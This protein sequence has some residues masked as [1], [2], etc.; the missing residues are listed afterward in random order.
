MQEIRVNK[1]ETYRSFVSKKRNH[2]GALFQKRGTMHKLRVYR[3]EPCRS[4]VSKRG[5]MQELR[6][7]REE[8]CRSLVSR[9]RHIKDGEPLPIWRYRGQQTACMDW[10]VSKRGSR[11]NQDDR[12]LDF[13]DGGPMGL[14]LRWWTSVIKKYLKCQTSRI[15]RFPTWRA[16]GIKKYKK[17]RTSGTKRFPRWRAF[18]IKPKMVKLCD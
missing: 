9:L 5:T 7:N 16:S 6:V 14:S 13:Q 15:E 18:V 17:C 11:D 4:F 8:P 3:E 10:E 12:L 1:E 2:S